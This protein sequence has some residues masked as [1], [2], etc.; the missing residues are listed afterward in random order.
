MLNAFS[1]KNYI[2][3][4][5]LYYI[6]TCWIRTHLNTIVKDLLPDHVAF[7]SGGHNVQEPVMKK[8]NK[9][10]LFLSCTNSRMVSDQTYFST[11][12][13]L[14]DVERFQ[15]AVVLSKAVLL[16]ELLNVRV[17]PPAG[18]KQ[19]QHLIFFNRLPILKKWRRVSLTVSYQQVKS[20]S[21]PPRWM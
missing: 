21:S 12:N 18:K 8:T 19:Q 9:T 14:L 1:V 2:L 6:I 15:L 10:E 3:S 7:I 4:H 13:T 11:C 17:G 5:N 16:H 20:T